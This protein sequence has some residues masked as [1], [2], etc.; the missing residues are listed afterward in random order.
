M[1]ASDVYMELGREWLQPRHY[2][3]II[4][5]RVA[6]GKCGFPLCRKPLQQST[7]KNIRGLLANSMDFEGMKN[8][9]SSNCYEKSQRYL[10][11]L[12]DSSPYS[13]RCVSKLDLSQ[14]AE[15]LL[16]RRPSPLD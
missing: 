12:V 8:Y 6:D 1:D 5:E 13:R 16:L 15:G 2:E 10:K 9:C 11:S 4:D 7:Q 14:H 3:E